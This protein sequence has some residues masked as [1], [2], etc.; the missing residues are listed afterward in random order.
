[1][2]RNKHLRSDNYTDCDIMY[3]KPKPDTILFGITGNSYYLVWWLISD[4][5]PERMVVCE[6]LASI[7]CVTSLLKTTDYRI[8]QKTIGY[9]MSS[10]CDL[11][12]PENGLHLIMQCPYY[13]DERVEMYRELESLGEIWESRLSGM[14]QEIFHILLGKQPEC[15]E[16][17]EMLGVW[18]ISGKHI[19]KCCNRETIAPSIS[20]LPFYP[21]H[22]P[23]YFVW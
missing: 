15:F 8:K 21:L 6:S 1:M 9:K 19:S 13:N 3:K 17:N 11:G 22:L 7:V 18:L 20:E 12:I 4:I 14:S 16:F 10:R 5:V 23:L 2:I